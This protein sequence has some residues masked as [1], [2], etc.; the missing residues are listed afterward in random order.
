MTVKEQVIRTVES[1]DGMYW[2]NNA[3]GYGHRGVPDLTIILHGG[4]IV[5]V[6]IKE[7]NDKERPLQRKL[8]KLL[9]ARGVE[10]LIA[11]PD[12]VDDVC[13]RLETYDAETK[14]AS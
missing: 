7:P 12:T 13:R 2:P 3:T 1:I 10:R 4:H 11:T 5:L 14:N 8:A 6:E 9:A